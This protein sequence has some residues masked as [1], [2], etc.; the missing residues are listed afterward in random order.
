MSTALTLDCFDWRRSSDCVNCV[1]CVDCVDCVECSANLECTSRKIAH[2]LCCRAGAD[3]RRSRDKIA[4]VFTTSA[5]KNVPE[6]EKLVRHHKRI[7]E[8]PEMEKLVFTTSA[9]L[10]TLEIEKLVFITSAYPTD[11]QNEKACVFTT[12]AGLKTFRDGESLCVHHKRMVE[13]FF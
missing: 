2:S 6:M 10:N 12:S 13:T 1:D 11:S 4:C 7:F 5:L 3:E 8:T 9:C